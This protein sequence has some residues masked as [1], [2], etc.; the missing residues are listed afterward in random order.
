MIVTILAFIAGSG[1]TI[2]AG[3]LAERSGLIDKITGHGVD[4]ITSEF[5]ALHVRLE[6]AVN[7]HDAVSDAHTQDAQ[8]SAAL[9]LAAAQEASKAA[10]IADKVG[11]LIA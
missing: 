4:Q 5:H 8:T 10:R 7:H 9:A 11:S 2:A 3:T 6:E 1:A